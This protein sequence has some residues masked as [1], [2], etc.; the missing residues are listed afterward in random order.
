ML[1]GHSTK[2]TTV[3]V[4]LKAYEQTQSSRGAC[5]VPRVAQEAH[6]ADRVD[7]LREEIAGKVHRVE[8][9]QLAEDLEEEVGVGL[10]ITTIR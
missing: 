7:G 1:G 4:D 6:L 10:P 3:R 9:Q 5:E 2:G 8:A